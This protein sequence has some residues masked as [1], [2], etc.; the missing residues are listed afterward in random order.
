[1]HREARRHLHAQRA[2]RGGAVV[3]DVVEGIFQAVEGFHDRRQQMLPGLGQH[4]R[5]RLALEQ[6]RADQ[7]FER[8]HM[9]RQ[10]ALRNQQRVGR[11]GEARMLGDALEGAQC[12]QRQPAAIDGGL[13]HELRSPGLG[14]A[15]GALLIGD[16][17]LRRQVQMIRRPESR[18]SQ[19]QQGHA[20]RRRIRRRGCRRTS[21]SRPRPPKARRSG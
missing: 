21:R 7:F 16:D 12:I 18:G 9:A 15:D 8:D 10:G 19:N 20:Q 17:G 14:I 4:Q 11:R 2:Q 13:A 3:A 6:L 1:M 5:M